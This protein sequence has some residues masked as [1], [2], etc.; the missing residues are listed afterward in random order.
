[1]QQLVLF[2]ATVL[3]VNEAFQPDLFFALRGGMNNFGIV[4]HFTIRVFPAGKILGGAVTLPS[5]AKGQV[6][7]GAYKLNT[8]WKNDT[9]M[10]FWYSYKY[11]ATKD[12]FNLS[13]SQAYTEPIRDPP[14][15]RAINNIAGANTSALRID[16][17]SSFAK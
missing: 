10:T 13:F 16:S 5:E 9:A 15:F 6:A 3:T 17:M 11:N 1:M 7:E 4:T 8:Q 12:T 2:N 14:P